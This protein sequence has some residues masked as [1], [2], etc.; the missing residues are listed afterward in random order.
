MFVFVED[1]SS[2]SSLTDLSDDSSETTSS[3]SSASGTQAG[4]SKSQSHHPT[5]TELNGAQQPGSSLA[6][7]HRTV[8]PPSSTCTAKDRV[9]KWVEKSFTEGVNPDETME[10]LERRVWL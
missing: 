8:E 7:G 9:N 3:N 10:Q 2:D 1:S 4:T 5:P 6:D